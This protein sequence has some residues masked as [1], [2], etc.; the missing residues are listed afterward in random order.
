MRRILYVH[1]GK[2]IGGAPLSLLYLIRGLDRS[3]Y[4]PLVLCI[5]DGEAADLYR[6]EG[7]D[8]VVDTRLHD[9]SH[10]N[11]LWYPLW[12]LPKI[13]LRLWQFPL[14]RVRF[15]RFLRERPVDLIHLN[16]STLTAF[17]LAGHARGIP[18]VWH[19]REPLQRGHTGLRRAVIRRIIDR[20]A[21]R[22][23]PICQYDA[24]QLLPSPNIHVVYNFIDF[25]Q[26]D[27]GIDGG[28]LRIALGIPPTA[29]VVTM[30]GGVNPIKGTRE[31][32][33]A[34]VSLLDAHPDALFLVAGPVPE[35][36]LRNRINGR[37]VYDRKLR[38]LIPLQHTS[39]IRFLGVRKDIPQ[40]LAASDL[41]CFPSTVPHFARPVIEASAMGVPVVASDLGGPR[42]LVRHEKTGLLF[43]AGDS[44]AL[45]AAM[46]RLLVDEALR[47]AMGRTGIT[48]A[49]EHFDA[50][51]NT[52]RVLKQ[53][54]E[55][56]R[57]ENLP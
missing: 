7:I 38:A 11:V 44:E 15:A 35:E 3:R 16:T 28:P 34:A 5:H 26:F 10:T 52:A 23:L 39:R 47:K 56:F 1:H 27:A 9:F 45:A 32:V 57:E 29:Q 37:C 33:Q 54:E 40:L 48:F 43:P 30:L 55:I 2:G 22:I 24:D 50:K 6:G 18:V 8:T 17:A 46:R 49:R 25:A 51:K 36:N 41:L 20:T 13:L 21:T 12:Q 42:E 4:E 31:F 19:I 14:T 53:Y